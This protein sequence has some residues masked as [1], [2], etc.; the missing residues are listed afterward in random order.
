MSDVLE[1]AVRF[2]KAGDHYAQLSR[3]LR[4]AGQ[5]WHACV[6]QW[7]AARQYQAARWTMRIED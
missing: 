7:A 3:Q 4:Q 1:L 2:Q 6:Y 5:L